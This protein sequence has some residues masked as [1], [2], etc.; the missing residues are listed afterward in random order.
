MSPVPASAS[1]APLSALPPV[2]GRLVTEAPIGRHTWFGVGGAAEMLFEP[3]DRDDLAG[4]L[5]ALPQT[6]PVTVIGGGANLLVRDGGIPGVTIRLGRSFQDVVAEDQEI[7]AGAA[8]L[9]LNASW[10]AA[11][12]GIAGFE[13]LS[14]IPGTIGGGLRMNAGA[15]GR[16]IENLLVS[17]TAVDRGGGEHILVAKMM[18][19]S[20][21][22]CSVDEDWIFVAARLRGSADIPEAIA[23]RM[24]EIRAVREA[25][26]PIRARTGGSTFKNTAGA[27]A[28]R[29]IDAA[30]CRGLRRGGAMVSPKHANFLINIGNAT[31]ADVEGLGEEVRR[32]VYQ[33]SGIILEWE[34]CRVGRPLAGFE[35]IGEEVR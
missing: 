20:Y 4:F 3:A 16:G 26:Q 17:A 12:K 24:A 29:L 31:A 14:G 15:Y 5:A 27:P 2:R 11:E 22:R 23:H 33:N 18:G 13:F 35:P 10:F 30:G 19:F 21:R 6:V 8:A 25:T 9:H 7:I 28:W 32:R 1:A 34:I